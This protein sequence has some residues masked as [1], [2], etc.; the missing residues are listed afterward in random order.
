MNLKS[1]VF[2]VGP[3][4]VGKSEVAFHLAQ[5]IRGEIVSCD[6]TQ[7]YKEIAIVN[8]KP[9]RDVL[10]TVTHHLVDVVSVEEEFHVARFNQLALAAVADIHSRD[11]IPLIVG[12]SG[13]Y[14]EILLDGI[15]EGGGKD[16]A[17]RGELKQQARQ[18]GNQ[19]LYDRLR[20]ED[21][22]AAK[23]IHPN[24]VRRVVRALEVRVLEKAPISRLRRQREGIWGKYDIRLFVL[25][26]ERQDLYGRIDRRVE[27]MVESG[28]VEEIEK[29]KGV[30]WSLTAQK[31]IGVQEV[32]GFLNQEY[33]LMKA[34]ELM[35]LNTRRLAKRQLTWFRRDGRLEWIMVPPGFA[36][37]AIA[38]EITRRCDNETG[39]K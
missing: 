28:L 1:I 25:N 26:M 10:K 5:S 31:I 7:V 6:S 14:M 24:D 35:K 8:N 20:K 4:A 12:G 16:E 18:Y 36:P 9:P 32:M 39:A 3:T 38:G 11:R 30:R 13:L 37:E 23:K 19:F 34:K 22:D 17:L 29:L 21:G 2:I 15:F 33:D 27:Q